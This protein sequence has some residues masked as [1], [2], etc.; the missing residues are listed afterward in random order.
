MYQ[1]RFDSV[2]KQWEVLEQGILVTMQVVVVAVALSWLFGM[3]FAVCRLSRRR[4]LSVASQGYVEFFRSTPE[5][6]QIFWIYFCLPIFFDIRL[7]SFWSGIIALTLF[8]SAYGSEI[9]R[10][11]IQAVPRGHV[12]AARSLGMSLS[13][14][15]RRIVLPQA[16][17]I[18]IPP[19][20][21]HFADM[22]KVSALLYTIVVT[23]LMY[24]TMILASATFRGLEFLTVTAFLYFAMIYPFSLL[25]R[26]LEVRLAAR[27]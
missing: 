9:F 15:F 2:W 23:E 27:L 13:Q 17:R 10:A 7:S 4:W 25:A 11:G 5:L 24:E 22:V 6:V 14:T 12:E 20:V 26:W 1:L 18:M 21:N 3:L 16:L 8:G 19:L